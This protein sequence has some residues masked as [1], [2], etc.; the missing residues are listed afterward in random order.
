MCSSAVGV[1]FAARSIRSF[2][3]RAA[4]RVPRGECACRCPGTFRCEA[5]SGA[6]RQRQDRFWANRRRPEWR[7]ASGLGK[8]HR[9]LLRQRVNSAP[10][11]RRDHHPGCVGTASGGAHRWPPPGVLAGCSSARRRSI[12]LR[13][14]PLVGVKPRRRARR[15]MRS[16]PSSVSPRNSVMPRLRQ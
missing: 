4:G 12:V 11:G 16:S 13:S 1:A 5:A 14:A 6:A 2:D 10:V 15:C 7:G 8:A 3:A 9:S